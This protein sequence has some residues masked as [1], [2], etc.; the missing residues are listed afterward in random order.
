M[1][2]PWDAFKNF[3]IGSKVTEISLS[4]SCSWDALAEYGI[5]LNSIEKVQIPN[6]ISVR[7]VYAYMELGIG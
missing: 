3:R 6:K 1:S 4:K 2:C 5:V 7:S